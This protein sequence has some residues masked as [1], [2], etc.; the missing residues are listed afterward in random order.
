MAG[1][2]RSYISN[3]N[4]HAPNEAVIKIDIKKFFASVPRKAVLRFLRTTCRCRSDVAK[5]LADLLT[6]E[7]KIP[8]GSSTSPIIAYY[9]F[10][11]M[12]D[13]IASLARSLGLTFTCY[14][15]DMTFS[16]TAANE[17]TLMEVRRIIAKHG[18]KSHKIRQF[19]PTVAKVLTGVCV[20]ASGDRVPNKLHLKIAKDFEAL[21]SQP[22][23]RQRSK[24]L[25]SLRGRLE[26]AGRI[27]PVFKA[28]ATTLRAV[29]RVKST[30]S[31]DLA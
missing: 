2:G 15:D 23:S 21:A 13:E 8:T 30:A 20:T 31:N 24:T 7:G 1:H 28:R 25:S 5:L 10:K 19:A 17:T 11:P 4:A 26:A 22:E 14:V 16:G 18:L 29:S 27:D 3:A 9:A 12:F 6:F